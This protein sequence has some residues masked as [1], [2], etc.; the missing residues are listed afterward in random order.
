LIAD[1]VERDRVL[2]EMGYSSYKE[3]LAGKVWSEI[4]IRQIKKQSWCTGC[5]RKACQV[6][7]LRYDKATLS[8]KSS[9]F[10]VSICDKCHRQIEF[11]EY[12]NKLSLR[13]ANERLLDKLRKNTKASKKNL[14]MKKASTQEKKRT[15]RG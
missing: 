14:A 3:Y 11:D 12:N 5:G 7:H 9:R 10:I 13:K 2:T 4:R 6:H 15:R 8:G 1:Y